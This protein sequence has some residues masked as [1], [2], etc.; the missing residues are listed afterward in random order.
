[1]EAES[2]PLAL[3]E[4]KKKKKEKKEKDGQ[5][6]VKKDSSKGIHFCSNPSN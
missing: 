1:M 2:E 4:E 6:E 3:K 5:D